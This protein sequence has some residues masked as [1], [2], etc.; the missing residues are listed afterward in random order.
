M[1]V[2][3]WLSLEEILRLDFPYFELQAW[4]GSSKHLGGNKAT[5]ELLKGCKVVK[6]KRALDVGCGVGATACMLAKNYGC[7]V[8]GIDITPRMVSRSRERAAKENLSQIATFLTADVRN[9]PFEDGLFDIV[10][11]ESVLIFVDDKERA[12]KEMLRVT[13]PGGYIGLNEASW[14][15]PDPP[16]EAVDFTISTF[17]AGAE[18]LTSDDWIKLLTQAG[19]VDIVAQKHKFRG[20]VVDF[21]EVIKHVGLGYALRALYRF[22]TAYFLNSAF[23]KYLHNHYI[24]YSKTLHGLLGYVTITGKKS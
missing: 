3:D 12:I 17:G 10:I 20:G 6:G 1:G 24:P 18:M 5:I 4:W 22:V 13:K 15:L 8:T 14:T 11:A 19:L 16:K 23:R 21:V 7:N 9:L 2:N